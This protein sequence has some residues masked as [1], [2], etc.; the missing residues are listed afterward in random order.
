MTVNKRKSRIERKN[1][2]IFFLDAVLFAAVLR[3]Y[4]TPER[5]KKQK[6]TKNNN[7]YKTSSKREL[8]ALPKIFSFR[9][10]TAFI[11]FWENF[12]IFIR[13]EDFLTELQ[14]VIKSCRHNSFYGK[15][16]GI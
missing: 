13:N 7:R 9:R 16:Q 2:T 15:L 11:V 4:L 6:K 1:L 10:H 8:G 12:R 14:C 5:K 3:A